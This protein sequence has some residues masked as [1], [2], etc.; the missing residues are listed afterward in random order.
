V[1]D[2]PLGFRRV[3]LEN[4]PHDGVP[5]MGWGPFL[6]E[7]LLRIMKLEPLFQGVTEVEF[8]DRLDEYILFQAGTMGPRILTSGQVQLRIGKWYVEPTGPTKLERLGKLLALSARRVQRWKHTRRPVT[9][10]GWYEFKKEAKS[11]LKLL[12]TKLARFKTV[13][14]SLQSEA[15]LE[16]V[17]SL[18]RPADSEFPALRRNIDPL[19]KYLKDDPDQYAARLRRGNFD[20]TKPGTR[21]ITAA[22]FFDCWQAWLT[23]YDAAKLRST[24]SN[25]G[26]LA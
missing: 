8:Y 10:P 5:E 21:K 6:D 18:I 7:A 25:L 23:G 19:L 9:D 15:F 17:S 16:H 4:I 11:E 20:R 26:R 14:R 1:K 13:N 3:L 2:N 12:L 24:I 22:A